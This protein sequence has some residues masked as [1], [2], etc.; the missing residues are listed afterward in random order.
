MGRWQH[1]F[2]LPR[3]NSSI[4]STKQFRDDNLSKCMPAHT[5]HPIQVHHGI[6]AVTEARH[7]RIDRKIE[8]H[9]MIIRVQGGITYWQY[10]AAVVGRRI[11]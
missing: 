10:L 2:H 8:R 7:I 3:H 11:Y 9:V 6:L 5:L 4:P 1:H